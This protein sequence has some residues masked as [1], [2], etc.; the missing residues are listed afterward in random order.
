M[1]NERMDKYIL[2]NTDGQSSYGSSVNN[3]LSIPSD[4][5]RFDSSNQGDFSGDERG[6]RCS[7]VNDTSPLLKASYDSHSKSVAQ[8]LI[9]QERG[10][11]KYHNR[12]PNKGNENQAIKRFE[13]T[14]SSK[15]ITDTTALIE[16]KSL[17]VAS[18][19]LSMTFLLQCSFSTVSVFTAGHLGSVELASVSIGSMTA[20]IS[21]YAII[22]GISSALDTLCPQAFG[23]KEYYLVGTYLQKCVAMNFTIMVPI[24]FIWTF[25]GYEVITG[26]LPDNDT[27][28][29]AAVYLRYTAPGIPAYILFEC[30]KKFLEAQ[31]IYH[32][33]TIVLLFAAPSNL[34]MNLLL[35]KTFGYIG[36][37]MAISINYW[38]MTFGLFVSIVYFIKP[39]STPSGKHPLTCWNGLH[40]KQAFQSWN[41]IV[42]LAVPGLVMLEAK[43]FALETLTL[44][45]SYLGTLSLAAQSV[46][47]AIASL[48][49]QVLIAIGIASSTRIA[50]FL[51]AG[52][53]S[54]AKKTTQVSL[55]FVLVFSIINVLFLYC[56]Q[57]RIAP[58]FTKDEKVIK[59]VESI[60]WLIALLQICDAINAGSA[61]CL[62]GQGQTKIGGIVSLL[63]YYLI[64]I[65]L[66]IYITVYSKFKGTIDGLWIGNCAALI[67][68]GVVQ[69]YY[70][71][72]ADFIRLCTDA[73][74]R[75]SN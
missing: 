5:D 64:G 12:I 7:S 22:Q 23:A 72:F 39:H 9:E 24:L 54:A 1:S 37:P 49:Y 4:I 58:L 36:I 29:Y 31:G 11:L 55:C 19:P 2:S 70:A 20:S 15:K 33:S 17:F 25:F 50:N 28:K 63:S 21:G 52:S 44:I 10:F 47:T 51:G 14:I 61:G 73:Q 66:S 46:G 53:N 32:I 18:V 69:S 74:K 30:G 60:M 48:S 65:P 13:E 41:K 40:I 38:L 43:F 34:V 45:A 27:A 62:R 6:I 56:F 26:F 68:I 57:T 3:G 59:I 75:A 71:L 67:I 42:Y 35:V 16:L 8:E